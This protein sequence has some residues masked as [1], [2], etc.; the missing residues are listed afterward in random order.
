MVGDAT[1]CLISGQ[2][3]NST[4]ESGSVVLLSASRNE[5]NYLIISL[6]L[7][8]PTA[9]GKPQLCR[10]SETLNFTFLLSILI[11]CFKLRNPLLLHCNRHCSSTGFFLKKL[12]NDLNFFRLKQKKEYHLKNGHKKPKT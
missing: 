2:T 1:R 12:E 5:S 9:Q 7:H 8:T 6:L 11:I 3:P 10:G 4:K